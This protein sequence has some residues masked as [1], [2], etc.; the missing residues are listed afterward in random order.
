M[1]FKFTKPSNGEMQALVK[2]GLGG[3]EGISNAQIKT[4]ATGVLNLWD[5]RIADYRTEVQAAVDA[6]Q[7]QLDELPVLQKKLDD[8]VAAHAAFRTE[9][10]TAAKTSITDK[11]YADALTAAGLRPDLIANE[12]RLANRELL[13]LDETGEAL[14]DTAKAI[15]DAKT[16]WAEGDFAIEMRSGARTFVGNRIEQEAFVPVVNQTA[17]AAFRGFLENATR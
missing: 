14:A 13:A 2:D 3:I 15:A 11:L 7:T 9:T 12:L 10:Q 16:R 4:I 6:M 1:E 17:N 5:A 8:E